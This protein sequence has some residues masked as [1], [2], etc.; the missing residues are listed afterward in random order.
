MSTSNPVQMAPSPEEISQVADVLARL[1]SGF[2]PKP[3]FLE[4]ARLCTTPTIELVP[5]RSVGGDVEV[6]LIQRPD[7]DPY[8]PSQWHVPGTVVRATDAGDS[9]SK[10]FQRL[11]DDELQVHPVAT[12]QRVGQMLHKVRRGTELANIFY[13]DLSD[14]ET[15][16]GNWYPAHALPDTTVGTQRELIAQAV[17]LFKGE[18]I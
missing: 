9:F 18:H 1:H 12:P 10:P 15:P 14:I 11:Y 4:V 7:D 13:I 17:K 3:I 5:L 16:V 6:L 2:L 8:W